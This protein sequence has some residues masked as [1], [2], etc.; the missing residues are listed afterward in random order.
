[1][2][3][4]R[5]RHDVTEIMV[6][7]PTDSGRGST[8]A[9]V[10]RRPRPSAGDYLWDDLSEF[11]QVAG[12]VRE[13]GKLAADGVELERLG[14]DLDTAGSESGDGLLDIRHVDAEVVIAGVAQTIAENSRERR[15]EEDCRHPA[16]RPGRRRRS[17]VRCKRAARWHRAIRAQ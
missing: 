8:I 16:A 4:A 11:D 2:P 17:G 3:I 13:E 12:R 15:S 1:R 10:K 9:R 14:H 6:G 5:F 7:S